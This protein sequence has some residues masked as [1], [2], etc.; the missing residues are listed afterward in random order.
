[1]HAD[2]VSWLRGIALPA[3]R[4]TQDPR[5]VCVISALVATPAVRRLLALYIAYLES[6]EAPQD[7][8]AAYRAAVALPP[9]LTGNEPSHSASDVMDPAGSMHALHS[10]FLALWQV[11]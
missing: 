7:A 3:A 6:D 11:V 8:A 5:L 4:L 10:A 9:P 2:G 1:M